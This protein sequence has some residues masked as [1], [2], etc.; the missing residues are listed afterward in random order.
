MNKVRQ[1]IFVVLAMYASAA[2]LA[3]EAG[4]FLIG[5]VD[6]K[7]RYVFDLPDKQSQCDTSLQDRATE[8]LGKRSPELYAKYAATHPELKQHFN[9]SSFVR[10][11]SIGAVVPE[12]IN[13]VMN[14]VWI[15]PDDPLKPVKL[16][17]VLNALDGGASVPCWNLLA[18]DW[19]EFEIHVPKDDSREFRVLQRAARPSSILKIIT[20]REKVIRNEVFRRFDEVWCDEVK[21]SPVTKKCLPRVVHP[22]T[23]AMAK[24]LLAIPS[25]QQQLSESFRHTMTAD[26]TVLVGMQRFNTGVNGKN[27][28]FVFAH[29][30]DWPLSRDDSIMVV[31]DLTTGRLCEYIDNEYIAHYVLQGVLTSANNVTDAWVV[32]VSYYEGHQKAILQPEYKNGQCSIKKVMMTGY[33]GL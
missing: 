21:Q 10:P 25:I 24:R 17:A 2:A 30:F 8:Y 1:L 31:A 3:Y 22:E 6:A 7:G 5:S 19:T 28:S 33:S 9:V 16:F 18:G 20:P 32:S 23:T 29:V 13:Q 12:E 4:D 14:Q 27:H 15:W 11:E 26:N